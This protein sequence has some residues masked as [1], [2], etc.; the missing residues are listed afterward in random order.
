MRVVDSE[1]IFSLG[2]RTGYENKEALTLNIALLLRAPRGK[3][4][5]IN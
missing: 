1:I 2:A 5:E 3:E 4:L